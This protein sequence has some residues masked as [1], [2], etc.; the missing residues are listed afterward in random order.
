MQHLHNAVYMYHV[1]ICLIGYLS[2]LSTVYESEVE[3]I[4]YSM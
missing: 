4:I 3:L 2:A 1:D